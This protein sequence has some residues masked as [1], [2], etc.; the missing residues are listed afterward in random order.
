MKKTK[1]DVVAIPEIN[2]VS[3]LDSMRKA[4][5]DAGK[6]LI[7]YLSRHKRHPAI[8]IA[9]LVIALDEYAFVNGQTAEQELKS[10]RGILRS[11][12]RLIDN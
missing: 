1:P 6:R 4:Y 8:D 9:A 11:I 3:D 5:N 12:G 2:D 10:V 7:R